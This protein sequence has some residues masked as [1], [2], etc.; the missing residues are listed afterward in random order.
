ML[1]YLSYNAGL[2]CIMVL[3]GML[4]PE[5]C[6]G[7][8]PEFTNKQMRKQRPEYWQLGMGLNKGS[9]RDFATSPITYKGVLFNYS[10]GY[11]KMD[12]TRETRFS[13]RF[14]H[15]TYKYKR[16]DGIDLKAKTSMYVLYL[17]Y[18]KLY[19]LEKFSNRKWNVKL[20]G[21]ADVN[22]DVRI[23]D[24]L[25][26]AGVGYEVFNTFFLSGKVTRRFKRHEEVN[27]KF[28]FIKYRLNPM[29]SMLSYQLNVPVM[30]NTVR[31]GFAYIG[32]EGIN[33]TPVFKGYEAKA[34]SGIRLCSELAYTRQIQNGNM[35]RLA[36]WWDAYAAG[37]SFNRFEM[38]NHIV[39]FS[40][41]FHLDKNIQQ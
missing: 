2:F 4:L 5:Y 21:M 8:V 9:M 11:I 10:F 31:N 22:M 34:F 3:A 12:T 36:Y 38:A 7:Q 33:T 32:N 41:L 19:Q 26:N 16:T 20:G 6:N 35:W 18:Q 13:T 30:N 17:N 14:N 23:N 24:D 39:E 25:M 28:L 29:V 27:K 15:G 40:L 37:K 1:R